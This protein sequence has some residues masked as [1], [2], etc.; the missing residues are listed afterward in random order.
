MTSKTSRHAFQKL[1]DA[2]RQ[3]TV[4][5]DAYA[6]ARETFEAA[7]LASDVTT[8]SYG[9]R[10]PENQAALQVFYAATRELRI[11]SDEHAVARTRLDRCQQTAG[12]V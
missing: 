1:A 8:C 2:E 7:S 4:T 6:A 10:S 11:A 12:V 9:Y 5:R 3:F